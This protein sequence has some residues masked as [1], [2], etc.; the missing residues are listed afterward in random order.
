MKRFSPIMAVLLLSSAVSFAQ[1]TNILD[2][3]TTQTVSSAWSTDTVWVGSDSTSN[4]LYVVSNAV[5]NSD[6]V[7]VGATSNTYYNEISMTGT[8]RWDIAG[9]L[10]VGYGESNTVSITD[11][12]VLSATGITLY[13]DNELEVDD[14]GSITG[15]TSMAVYSNSTVSG[16]G[17]I[18]FAQTNATLT[19]VGTNITVDADIVF[20]ANSNFVNTLAY[21]DSELNVSTFDPD[22]YENFGNLV[23]TDSALTG[24]GTVDYFDSI[25]MTGGSILP[26]GDTS[27]TLTIA[28]D[29]SA[30]DTTY[31]A[32]VEDE[33]NDLLTFVDADAFDLSQLNLDLYVSGTTTG[34]VTILSASNGLTNDFADAEIVS[35]PLLYDAAIVLTNDEVQ[36]TLEPVDA[37]T[38][39]STLPY[40]ATETVRAGFGGMKNMVFTRT[41]QLRRNLVATDHA[42]PNDMLQLMTTNAP[43]GAMGPGDQN[44]IFDM[45]VWLQYFNGQGEYDQSGISDGFSLNNNGSTIGFDRMVGEALSVGVNYTYAR[46]SAKADSGDV[47]DSETYWFGAYGEW[48]GVEGL[49]VDALAAYGYS[50]YDSERYLTS[51]HGTASYNGH[52]FGAS[53]DVGQYYYYG[54]HL[55]FSPYVGLQALA[56]TLASHTETEDAGSE[57]KVGDVDRQW[58]ES[59]LGLKLRHRFDSS[60]GRFQLTGYAEWTYDFIQDDVSTTLAS[61]SLAATQTEIIS[62][63][64]S[65]VNVGIGYSWMRNEYMEIGIGYNGRFSDSYEEHTGSLMLDIMF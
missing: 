18:A 12:S 54:N 53:A 30:E 15:L 16:E 28:D 52:A 31:F 6:D 49:Y 40:A 50:T 56:M 34:T 13:S 19:Y 41:K 63:D 1:Y 22:Q 14:G 20:A 38:I 39:G 46:S 33:A 44:T 7:Y 4:T 17:T 5:V 10:I 37:G 65:G 32:Q 58:L 62:T 42:I 2:D 64:D 21:S 60:V 43:A 29:F 24:S 45:H 23:M 8:S 27:G 55:A 25:T 9:Q 35:R 11:D 48:V 57:V 47:L 61:G 3:I 59:S 26:G 36:V 51:Y